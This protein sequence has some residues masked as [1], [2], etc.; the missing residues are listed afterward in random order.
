MSVK[1][2]DF[3]LQNIIMKKVLIILLSITFLSIT[4]YSQVIERFPVPQKTKV[5]T[6]SQI[7]DGCD[8]AKVTGVS[9]MKDN[10]TITGLTVWIALT[11]E[12]I[13][14]SQEGAVSCALQSNF[15][16]ASTHLKTTN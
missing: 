7:Y 1:G 3:K 13:R 4:A 12:G 16:G 15:F 14:K 5:P 11:Q 10:D 8:V 9:L 6:Y 2:A